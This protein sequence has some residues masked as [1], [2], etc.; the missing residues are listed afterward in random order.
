MLKF[1][2]TILLLKF[3]LLKTIPQA[4]P[5]I[6]AKMQ[7][8]VIIRNRYLFTFS[9]TKICDYSNPSYSFASH[10]GS[11]NISCINARVAL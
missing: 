9:I 6:L 2:N 4:N 3:Q 5:L 8:F 11:S 7:T 1:S 10:R